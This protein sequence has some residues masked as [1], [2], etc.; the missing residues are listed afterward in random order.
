MSNNI[1]R[2][3]IN[4]NFNELRDFI[5]TA[6][7]DADKAQPG[8]ST[9]HEL[10][11]KIYSHDMYRNMLSTIYTGNMTYKELREN[12]KLVNIRNTAFLKMGSLLEET[13]AI[14]QF[15]TDNIKEIQF[16]LQ[17]DKIENV[18]C[19]IQQEEQTICMYGECTSVKY[20]S[21]LNVFNITSP[22]LE[23][24]SGLQSTSHRVQDITEQDKLFQVSV[25]NE[26]VYTDLERIEIL[27]QKIL[28]K[29]FIEWA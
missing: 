8:V 29:G 2:F 3:K 13:E 6:Q 1:Q 16:A 26:F 4:Y 15:S 25:S 20:D 23:F 14:I 10:N 11:G 27:F 19:T 21:V 18:Y 5:D 22:T 28:Q 9:L 12:Q 24:K 7:N 17:D